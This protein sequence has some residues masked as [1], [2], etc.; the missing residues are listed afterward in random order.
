[1]DEIDAAVFFQSTS[2]MLSSRQMASVLT[3]NDVSRTDTSLVTDWLDWIMQWNEMA[4][5][6][7]YQ[8]ATFPH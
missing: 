3:E 7:D 6:S 1:M 5:Q 8:A 2:K 4:T